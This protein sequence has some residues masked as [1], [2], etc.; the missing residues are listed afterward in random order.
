MYESISRVGQGQTPSPFLP[1][2]Y[3]LLNAADLNIERKTGKFPRKKVAE[4][5]PVLARK[6]SG[7]VLELYP[8]L[9]G[10][11][12]QRVALD[13]V[14][15]SICALAVRAL[16]KQLSHQHFSAPVPNYRAASK[17][18]L[19][20]LERLRKRARRLALRHLGRDQYGILAGRWQAFVVWLRSRALN[21]RCREGN[22]SKRYRQSIINEVVGMVKRELAADGYPPQDEKS[23]RTWA[24][25]I[26]YNVRRGREQ[27]VGIRTLL[28]SE[29]GPA[30]VR[31]YVRRQMVRSGQERII[32]E[33]QG[34]GNG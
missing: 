22:G 28:Q 11:D 27:G 17:R 14:D 1:R 4:Y 5:D 2:D 9:H 15:L 31:F 12:R 24:K 29:S 3:F 32:N 18:F 6:I 33:R 21:C 8:V 25:R 19:R 34:E 20:V 16:R 30:V 13:C 26:V 10:Q 7:L 23:V